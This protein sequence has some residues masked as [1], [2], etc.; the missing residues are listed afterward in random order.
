ME[1]NG[2]ITSFSSEEINGKRRTYYRI[3]EAGTAYY[4]EKCEEWL[5]TK[6]VVGK[7]I[8]SGEN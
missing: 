3:T 6:E 8:M 7:F 2:Y 4:R 5:L 1:K